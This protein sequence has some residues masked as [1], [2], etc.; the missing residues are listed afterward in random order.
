MSMASPDFG[1]WS[2]EE[3]PSSVEMKEDNITGQASGMLEASTL[4]KWY[5]EKLRLILGSLKTPKA[6]SRSMLLVDRL[7]SF[8]ISGVKFLP[9]KNSTDRSVDHSRHSTANSTDDGFLE[10]NGIPG[11]TDFKAVVLPR[12]YLPFLVLHHGDYQKNKIP[13]TSSSIFH[14]V[15]VP[16]ASCKAARR[17]RLEVAATPSSEV[18]ACTEFLFQSCKNGQRARNGIDSM[19][20]SVF[21]HN[22]SPLW[23][24]LC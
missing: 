20:W 7:L 21:K 17:P 2:N 3:G 1:G 11:S 4:T 9:A 12:S 8:S 14:S 15:I 23:I 22:S 5:Q 24:V 6:C 13:T 10:L 18:N 16:S 19:Y